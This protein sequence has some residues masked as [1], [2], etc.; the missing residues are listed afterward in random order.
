MPSRQELDRLKQIFDEECLNIMLEYDIS[1]ELMGYD[2]DTRIVFVREGEDSLEKITFKILNDFK[3][4]IQQEIS[5]DWLIGIF[6]T[7]I[8]AANA[9][10]LTEEPYKI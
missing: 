8:A 9:H 1:M 6:Y 4:R 2:S 5:P 7:D 3:K 10:K